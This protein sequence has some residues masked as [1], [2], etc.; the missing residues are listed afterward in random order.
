MTE[1]FSNIYIE[2]HLFLMFFNFRQQ[3]FTFSFWLCY[4]F[5]LYMK[6]KPAKTA[7]ITILP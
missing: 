3:K 6:N 1:Y 5:L 7:R 4:D 2:H